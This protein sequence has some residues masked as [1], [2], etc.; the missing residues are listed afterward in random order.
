MKAGQS[1]ALFPIIGVKASEGSS[2]VL[3]L[4]GAFSEELQ[5]VAG[6]RTR[7]YARRCRLFIKLIYYEASNDP[8][9]ERVVMA[10]Q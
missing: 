7:S 9:E 1:C 5:K 6:T 4:R 3:P 10:I 8:E 2:K